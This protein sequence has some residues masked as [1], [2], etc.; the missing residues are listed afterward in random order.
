MDAGINLYNGNG[1]I[2]SQQVNAYV[3]KINNAKF[4]FMRQIHTLCNKNHYHDFVFSYYSVC[5]DFIE[6]IS[7]NSFIFS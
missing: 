7:E 1:T 5:L 3:F 2:S 4:V 6:I